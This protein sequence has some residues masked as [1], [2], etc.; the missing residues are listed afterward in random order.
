VVMVSADH[1]EAFGEHGFY[2]HAFW[3]WDV[4]VRV[5]LLV[6]GPGIEPRRIDERRSHVDLAPTILDLMGIEKQ[7]DAFVGHSLAPEIFGIETPKKRDVIVLDLPED[8]HNP[9]IRAVISGDY[10]IIRY[11]GWRYELYDLAKDP[12]ETKDLAKEM[13]DK[14]ADMK[15]VFEK[16]WAEI[17]QLQPF[18]GVK[19]R[20]GK[21]A[22]GPRTAAEVPAAAK[23]P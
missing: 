14:L 16:T 7:P 11:D 17:P 3:L 1:G 2:R 19:L 8:S 18:G 23:T 5:P 12:G 15:A 20:G 13:P 10:K 22:N 4:L 9:P 6:G 21:I